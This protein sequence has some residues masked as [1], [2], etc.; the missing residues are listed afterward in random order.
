MEIGSYAFK[1]CSGVFSESELVGYGVFEPASGDVTQIAVDKQ[2]RRR[3]IGSLLFL[4]M[5]ESNQHNSI[6]II[7]TDIECNS[8]TAF[9]KSKNIEPAGKQFEMKKK[10]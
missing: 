4:K 7:N 6:K 2:F 10:L 8:I 1:L 5:L 3:G 9:L